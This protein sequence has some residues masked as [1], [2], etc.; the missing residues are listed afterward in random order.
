[1]LRKVVL[2]VGAALALSL[3]TLSASAFEGDWYYDNNVGGSE[4]LNLGDNSDDSFLVLRGTDRYC[5]RPGAPYSRIRNVLRRNGTDG[6][7]ITW[8]IANTCDDGYVRIC[9]EN[10]RGEQACSTYEDYGWVW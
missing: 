5:G 8:W 6:E 1:M 2:G 7:Q 9:V 3:S 10:W 4:V